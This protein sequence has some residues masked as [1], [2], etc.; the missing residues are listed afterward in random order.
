MPETHCAQIGACSPNFLIQE[1]IRTWGGFHAEILKQP[2]RWEDGYIIPPSAPG[3]GVELDE[4]FAARHPDTGE[5]L[6]LEMLDRPVPLG[7]EAP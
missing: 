1:G 5:A 4:A 3:L 7:K 6:H 2:I